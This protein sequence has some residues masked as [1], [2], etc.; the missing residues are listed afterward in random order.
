MADELAS[1]AR[2]SIRRVTSTDDF[3]AILREVGERL[4][5][6]V[7]SYDEFEIDKKVGLGGSGKVHKAVSK[8]TGQMVALKEVNL[9]RIDA[10]R[11]RRYILEIETM[12]Q[13]LSP[14]IVSIVGFSLAPTYF[15]ASE[16]YARGP[17]AQWAKSRKEAQ[18]EP[19]TPT[20]M[21]I[22]ALG[23]A[24]GLEFFHSK[25]ILH[26]DLKGA[27]ILLDSDFRPHICDLGT[28]RSGE[29]DRRKATKLGTYSYM[30]PEVIESTSYDSMADMFS[31][32]IVIYE[33][34]ERNRALK[35]VK[36]ARDLRKMVVVRKEKP[37]IS[38]KAFW[39]F[40][41]A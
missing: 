20:Q 21:T 34:V 35:G 4:S 1:T 17:L 12:V 15:I 24:C 16:Y 38:V 19:L 14:Y 27:K 30:A 25:G 26:R 3:Q 18:V 31:Y 29:N 32:G 2:S 33:M 23:V 40:F 9:H 36:T 10:D 37:K 22:I 5:H 8:R 7:G 13:V 11:F 28:A 6:L 41:S 39:L